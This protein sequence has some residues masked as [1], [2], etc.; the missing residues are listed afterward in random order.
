[1]VAGWEHDGDALGKVL[2]RAWGITKSLLC[3]FLPQREVP[4]VHPKVCLDISHIG[5]KQPLLED[6]L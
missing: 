5:D 6:C 4:I 2:L 1:M 3:D